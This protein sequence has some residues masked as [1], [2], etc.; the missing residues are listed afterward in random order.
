MDMRER[1]GED[2]LLSDDNR[3]ACVF[4]EHGRKYRGNNPA[5]LRLLMYLVDGGML[6]EGERCDFL[7]GIPEKD[8]IYFVELKGKKL[9]VRYVVEGE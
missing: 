9:R 6:N 8:S 1:L 4:E 2:G 3:K 5:E 7:A